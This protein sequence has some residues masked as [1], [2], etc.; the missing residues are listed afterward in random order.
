MRAAAIP[1][2]RFAALVGLFS[3]LGAL[4]FLLTPAPLGAQSASLTARIATWKTADGTIELCIDLRDAAV[5]ETRQCPQHRRLTFAQT[6]ENRRLRSG[7]L[8]TAPEVAPRVRARRVGHQLAFSPG[9][10][11]DGPARCIRRRSRRA[12]QIG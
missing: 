8:H 6:P 1:S 10:P 11:H 3:L 7:S 2:V 4:G 9:V 5:G 12:C